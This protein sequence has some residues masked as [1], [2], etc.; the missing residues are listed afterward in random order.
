MRSYQRY[1]GRNGLQS[2]RHFLYS[3]IVSIF[4]KYLTVTHLL[5]TMVLR[6]YGPN[7]C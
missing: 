1:Q 3:P 7:H 5:I 2:Q 4:P 6:D